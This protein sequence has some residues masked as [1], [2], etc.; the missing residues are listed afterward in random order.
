MSGFVRFNSIRF[1]TA[2]ALENA[3]TGETTSW[4]ELERHVG[5]LA[6][7]LTQAHGVPPHFKSALRQAEHVPGFARALE[8][9]H[10]H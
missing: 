10:E 6:G 1:P 2:I 9:V 3:D 4:S 5:R 7:E 8:A